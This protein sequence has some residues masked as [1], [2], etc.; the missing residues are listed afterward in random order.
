[1]S[2]STST[3]LVKQEIP[4]SRKSQ[5]NLM[6]KNL[7]KIFGKVNVLRTPQR[8]GGI[9]HGYLIHRKGEKKG[10]KKTFLVKKKFSPKNYATTQEY[11]SSATAQN[12]CLNVPS[13][14]WVARFLP[15]VLFISQ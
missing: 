9:Q 15:L 12:V 3:V 14:D 11:N 1:V 10:N 4:F 13:W 5:H 2:Y 6:N 8:V 7:M